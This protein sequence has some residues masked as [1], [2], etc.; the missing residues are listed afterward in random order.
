MS[1]IKEMYWFFTILCFLFLAFNLEAV[2]GRP[3][4]HHY[5]LIWTWKKVVLIRI[6]PMN[7]YVL[8]DKNIIYRYMEA[9]E[10]TYVSAVQL[11][12]Y[13]L[14]KILNYRYLL[15]WILEP[16][17]TKAYDSKLSSEVEILNHLTENLA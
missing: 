2:P 3:W 17:I 16:P 5:A 11:D 13:A 14:V 15:D 9:S 1:K 10:K 4:H 12:T 6:F 7:V 8:V